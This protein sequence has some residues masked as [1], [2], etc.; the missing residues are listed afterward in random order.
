[1]GAPMTYVM[2][3]LISVAGT[4]G[5][6][7]EKIRQEFQSMKEC[8]QVLYSW[9]TKLGN[10][11]I[12]GQCYYKAT[13]P[14]KGDCKAWQQFSFKWTNYCLQKGNDIQ[15]QCIALEYPPAPYDHCR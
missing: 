14:L 6:G 5:W 7:S 13:T 1:M 3:I 4:H 11:Y 2:L 10:K 12:S 9:Q 8:Q 15:R